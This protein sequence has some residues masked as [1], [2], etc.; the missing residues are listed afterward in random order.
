[1]VVMDE[2]F[3][4]RYQ[5][6]NR[7]QRQAVDKIEGPLMVLAGP[8]TGKTE[9]LSM[10]VANILRQTDTLPENILCLTFTESG[11]AA[12]RKRLR[13][14]IGPSAYKVN[15]HTFHS[16]GSETINR[17]DQYF[18]QGSNF[19]PADDLSSYEV[20][21]EVFAE[22][23]H[24]NP[25]SIK[26]NDSFIYLDDALRTISELKRSGL[27][28]DEL[29]KVLDANDIIIDR[30]ERLLAPILSD[31]IDKKT[32]AK[33][34]PKLSDLRN[35]DES[36][37]ATVIPLSQII[38]DS[39]EGALKAVDE[40]GTT[41]PLTAWKN[42]WFKRD[43]NKNL[44]LKSRDR[45]TRLR[46]LS[47]VYYLYLQRMQEKE[48][49]DFDD[50]ILRVVH[51]MEVFPELR[52][53]LQEKYQYVM[54]DEFQDTNLAQMRILLNLVASEISGDQPNVMVVGDD[55]Q[56]IF[57]FQ[58][59]EVGN[60]NYFLE[61]FQQAEIISLTENYRSA[62]S[63]LAS[64]RNTI[65]L[66]QDRLENRLEWLDKN[67]K[68]HKVDVDPPVVRLL[69]LSTS[70]QERSWL[71]D[72]IGRRIRDGAAPSSFA[73]IARNHAQ[74]TAL[75]PYFTNRSIRVSYERRDNILEMPVIKLVELLG[76]TVTAI[77]ANRH[78]TVDVLL[79]ELL[80][81]PAFRIEPVTIWQLGIAAWRE[82]RGWLE[83][84][85]DS[86]KLG[87]LAQWLVEQAE[88]SLHTPLEH[89]IDSLIGV[90]Q[91]SDR[92][93]SPLYDFY[94]NQDRIESAAQ[95]YLL[96]LE[97]LRMIRGELR[98]YRNDANPLLK[99]LVDF[100]GLYRERGKSITLVRLASSPDEASVQLLTAHKAKGLE[101][102]NVY[103][104]D[105]T[106]NIWGQSVRPGS[107]KI[108]YPENLP[109]KPAGD[110]YDE[111][112]RI[113]FVA[114]TRAQQHLTVLYGRYDDGGREQQP[115]A[116]LTE[117]GWHVEQIPAENDLTKQLEV[118]KSN[119]YQP[120]VQPIQPDMRSLLAPTLAEYRLSS[121]HLNNF[122]DVS[123]GGPSNFLMQ[124]LLR[125]PSAMNPAAAYGSAVHAALQRAHAH[126][127]ANGSPRPLEDILNDYEKHLRDCRLESDDFNYYYQKGI[128]ALT[129]FLAAKA[130]TFHADQLAEVD[131]GHQTVI[132]D[133]IR[134]T[135]ELD[136]IDI[137]DDR[138]TVVDYKTGRPSPTWHGAQE[139]DKMKLHKYRNQLL[140]Y[141]LLI[142]NSRDF[143][144]Y[145]ILN[146]EIQFIEPLPSGEIITLDLTPSA[147]ERERFHRLVSAV[148]NRI[149]NLDLP[150]ITDFSPNL[151][152]MVDF[153]RWLID[154]SAPDT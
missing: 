111:R 8:G 21:R 130:G 29:L 117:A 24:K 78:A 62:P 126:L 4:R 138:L 46:G 47:Y 17:Y 41:K 69:E 61:L 57:S 22:L 77:A 90:N 72:D 53:N 66:A 148:W 56:A 36:P 5:S 67:L 82:R 104:I 83:T 31:K 122:L 23:D 124:N 32:A 16:F 97:S 88:L 109:L 147:D 51:A 42:T 115:A 27:T 96:C 119:W 113:F 79:P 70:A 40:T 75:L 154:K 84:M 14:I 125:F 99:D 120:V 48:L 28:S 58:G 114:A 49:Y 133:G 101:F 105:T 7:A 13:E 15:I 35:T 144:R 134:L 64:A 34:A 151:K 3:I 103:I 110:K 10:R 131:F 52:Y 68:P 1:M 38:T 94:F 76:R 135:G 54:V 132:I 91:S 71:A 95:D 108:D 86:A 2:S 43:A 44:V 9:L 112:L 146:Y 30:A 81:H 139:T 150:D 87:E 152:G 11:Q 140:F 50:M 143:G 92:Y 142:R 55:D 60:I 128:D 19:R 6:L 85:L 93:V 80:A 106:D 33:L 141:D 26:V 39:L 121:T 102:E 37:V 100:I 118:A 123:R 59:A 129:A 116:F 153:E 89:I 136:L 18:Y 73:V 127:R 65:T 63:I 45:Q 12:M 149:I 25:L 145:K 74:I 137:N 20:L 98:N 107:R